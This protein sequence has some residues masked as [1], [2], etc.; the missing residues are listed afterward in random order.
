MFRVYTRSLNSIIAP[1]GLVQFN[2]SEFETIEDAIEY[3]K[4]KIEQGEGRLYAAAIGF[5]YHTDEA[6]L[7]ENGELIGKTRAT[8][9]ISSD[10]LINNMYRHI[11][12]LINSPFIE[13]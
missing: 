8:V 9:V 2:A 7:N 12:D 4:R 5:V 6:G 11:T 13:V 1:L 10:R 3:L